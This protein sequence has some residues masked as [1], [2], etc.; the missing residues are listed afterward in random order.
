LAST[1]IL[2]GKIYAFE[3]HGITFPSLLKNIELNGLSERMVA[4]SMALHSQ[5]EL[6]NFNYLNLESAT[7][8]SQFSEFSDEGV[9]M[10]KEILELKSGISIDYLV[11]NQLIGPPTVIKIDVDGNAELIIQGMNELLNSEKPPR[12]ILVEVRDST[13]DEVC[14]W[15]QA[16]GYDIDTEL[17]QPPKMISANSSNDSQ[18]IVFMLRNS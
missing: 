7:T 13:R 18:N 17:T 3:P 4:S 5:L 10:K 8:A 12:S 14:R 11:S 6:F 16:R 1:Q 15:F 9:S 2:N